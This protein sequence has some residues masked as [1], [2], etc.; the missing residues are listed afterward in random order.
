MFLFGK[1]AHFAAISAD[2]LR[3]S[4]DAIIFLDGGYDITFMNYGAEKMFGYTM[5]EKL[6]DGFENLLPERFQ[7]DH[8]TLIEETAVALDT[9]EQ[10]GRPRMR[11]IFGRRSNGDEFA[12]AMT[13]YRV[14]QNGTEFAV[15]MKDIS[16]D[17]QAEEEL[18]KLITT[19][20]LTRVS[21]RREFIAMTER[22]A[23]RA[24]RYNRPLSLVVFDLDRFKELNDT[25][26]YAV[27][28]KVLQRVATLCHNMLRSVDV[29]GRLGG[30]EF[31]ALLPETDEEGAMVISERLRRAIEES[32]LNVD[33]K[34]LSFTMSAGITT[35]R[36]GETQIDVPL[37]RAESAL[38]QAKSNGRNCT[39]QYVQP[40]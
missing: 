20:P 14:Q 30:E 8:K 2:L 13:I 27:G 25:H 28:D 38:A 17:K 3:K 9:V 26:G 6:K 7:H 23:L 35:F 33:G 37:Q 1:K 40:S 11:Q 32:A 36:S 39:V 21:N 12:A 5:A 15:V 22:E 24:N 16:Q 31:A 29:F 19:D 10:G 18:L 4:E 34:K